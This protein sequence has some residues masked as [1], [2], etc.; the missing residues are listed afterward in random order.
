MGLAH[1][2]RRGE[3]GRARWAGLLAMPRRSA[4]RGQRAEGASSSRTRGRA[5]RWQGM[6]VDGER[7]TAGKARD[8]RDPPDPVVGNP[9][10]A[11]A[12]T[13]DDGRSSMASCRVGGRER[14]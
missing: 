11:T 4:T 2:Q 5:R 14:S 3:A 6:E 12:R 13:T 8:D 10:P 9:F 7:G 1:L